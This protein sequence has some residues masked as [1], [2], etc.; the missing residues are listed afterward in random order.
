MTQFSGRAHLCARFTVV[1]QAAALSK[2]SISS[3]L[4]GRTAS[5]PSSAMID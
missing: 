2:T 4:P 1:K 5:V 3:I